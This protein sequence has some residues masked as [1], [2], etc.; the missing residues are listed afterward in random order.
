LE[1]ARQ[2]ERG[3]TRLIWKKECTFPR[4]K[5]ERPEIDRSKEGILI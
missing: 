2:K 3:R 1:G 4:G 5:R